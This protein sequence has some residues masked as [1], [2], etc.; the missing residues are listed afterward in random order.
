ML[1]L[2]VRG[3]IVG[4]VRSDRSW[5]RLVLDLGRRFL[6]LLFSKRQQS[7]FELHL[8]LIDSRAMFGG[9]KGRRSM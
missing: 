8:R 3:L 4:V 6:S 9:L 2:A 7:S 1:G 5:G